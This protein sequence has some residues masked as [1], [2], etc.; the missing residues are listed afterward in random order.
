MAENEILVKAKQSFAS[1]TNGEVFQVTKG[2][3]LSLPKDA[4]WVKAGLVE[5]LGKGSE[6]ETAS[7][8]TPK[9]A[10]A[11]SAEKEKAVVATP[12]KTAAKPAANEETED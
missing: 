11:K 2:K 7:K 5:V 3:I 10:T 6:P 12:E 4:D 8:T 1:M 9:K